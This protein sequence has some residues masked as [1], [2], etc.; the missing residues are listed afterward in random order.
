MT[1]FLADPQWLRVRLISAVDAQGTTFRY[2][3]VAERHDGSSVEAFDAGEIDSEGRIIV[4]LT[5]AGPLGEPRKL[6][7]QPEI[8][9]AGGVLRG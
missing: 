5:F 2:R 4:L 7:G 3:A 9:S 6:S 8:G 1:R